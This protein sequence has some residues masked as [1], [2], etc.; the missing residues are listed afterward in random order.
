MLFSL[1]PI[2]LFFNRLLGRDTDKVKR[3]FIDMN[4][5]L[6]SRSLGLIGPLEPSSVLIL[7]PH[8]IQNSQCL[9]KVTWD[10]LDNCKLCNRCQIPVFLGLRRE[11][12]VEVVVVS[13]GTAARQIIKEKRPSFIIAVACENDLLSG[14]KDVRDITV[15]GVLNSRPCGACRDTVVDVSIIRSYLDAVIKR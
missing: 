5:R 2:S 10:K 13:G 1:Y 15:V 4:N 11:Y 14:I 9:H 8:C 7:L 3:K 12:G 6:A